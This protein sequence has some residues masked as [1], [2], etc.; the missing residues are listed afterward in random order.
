MTLATQRMAQPSSSGMA[1]S[2]IWPK[3]GLSR[4]RKTTLPP[5]II[6][7]RTPP[8]TNWA[9][10]FCTCVMSLVS[11]VTMDPAPSLSI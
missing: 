9:M 6:S 3:R 8:L 5:S 10:K 2:V 4:N 7:V 1:A 11:L